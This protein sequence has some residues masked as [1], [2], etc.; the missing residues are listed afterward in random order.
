MYLLLLA[1]LWYM[2]EF[3]MLFP[4]FFDV[5]VAVIGNAKTKKQDDNA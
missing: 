3:R 5:T 4:V 1:F 2:Q